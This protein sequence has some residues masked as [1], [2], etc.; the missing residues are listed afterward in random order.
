MQYRPRWI[1]SIKPYI[2]QLRRLPK[3]QQLHLLKVMLSSDK[4]E[5]SENKKHLNIISKSS[6]RIKTLDQLLEVAEVDHEMFHVHKYDINK[7]EV[8]A[9]I[10]G[11]M[12]TEELFQV[13]ASLVRNKDLQ[14]RKR[15]LED[16]H[17]D[18]IN[19]SPKAIKRTFSDGDYL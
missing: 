14:T 16:L 13:K 3:S 7:W 2:E 9:Q 4:I 8:A 6:S 17:H 11:R 1:D 18:F 10:D 12:V 19:H 5:T 15:I